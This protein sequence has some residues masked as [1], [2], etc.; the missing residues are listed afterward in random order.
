MDANWSRMMKEMKSK[1]LVVGSV[2]EDSQTKK[3]EKNK[4]DKK[5]QKENFK[6]LRKK[7]KERAKLSKKP[8]KE[9][10][11]KMEGF[12]S[13]SPQISNLKDEEN[14][15]YDSVD[16]MDCFEEN[17]IQ[18]EVRMTVENN[19]H[20][21]VKQQKLFCLRDGAT[22]TR[23]MSG[24]KEKNYK[25]F[26]KLNQSLDYLSETNEQTEEVMTVP[27][28]KITKVEE[29]LALDRKKGTISTTHHSFGIV[30]GGDNPMELVYRCESI[31]LRNDFVD[32]FKE[33]LRSG[34]MSGTTISDIDWL[35]EVGMAVSLLEV[36]LDELH[37]DCFQPPPVPAL[38][39]N[40]NFATTPAHLSVDSLCEN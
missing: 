4:I 25:A 35:I 29:D 5:Q 11:K 34:E 27:I 20:Y 37:S 6:T 33:L 38:P 19:V 1:N 31:R 10:T 39:P 13:S 30:V 9:V 28:S 16:P 3:S 8:K 32:G 26:I 2:R 23:V 21:F 17:E 15:C 14:D 24:K 22:F 18:K 40:F 12:G 7:E 36:G